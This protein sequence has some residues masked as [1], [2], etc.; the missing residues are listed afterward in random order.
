MKTEKIKVGQVGEIGDF[1]KDFAA[2]LSHDLAEQAEK[3]MIKAHDDIIDQYYSSYSPTSY[4]RHSNRNLY[5]TLFLHHIRPKASKTK[6]R[7]SI[8]V[9]PIDMVEQYN[10][11][12]ANI[13]DLVW[14]HGVRGLPHHGNLKLDHDYI[15]PYNK[16]I[17]F[18]KGEKWENRY[19]DIEKYGNVFIFYINVGDENTINAIPNLV[20]SDFVK[21]WGSGLGRNECERIVKGII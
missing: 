3:D 2:R 6:Y 9:G 1:I 18:Q 16:E 17:R 4:H 19:W 10:T 21:R 15:H 20:M 7:A 14:I 13:F 11:R 8:Y 5:N 12:A